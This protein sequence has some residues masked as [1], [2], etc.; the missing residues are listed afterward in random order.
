MLKTK[1]YLSNWTLNWYVS[2]ECWCPIRVKHG[3]CH[4]CDMSRFRWLLP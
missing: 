4:W 3:T 1:K 2:Y